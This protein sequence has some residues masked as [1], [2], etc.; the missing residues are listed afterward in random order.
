MPAQAKISAESLKVV[1]DEI[2]IQYEL[3][4]EHKQD[5]FDDLDDEEFLE[6]LGG[7]YALWAKSAITDTNQKNSVKSKQHFRKLKKHKSKKIKYKMAVL[8]LDKKLSHRQLHSLVKKINAKKFKHSKY[9]IANVFPNY[10][11]EI[12]SADQEVSV[13][14]NDSFYGQQWPITQIQPE[15]LWQYTKGA[16]AVVA[17]I[18]TG[19]DYNHEDLAENIWVNED[20]IPDNGKDDDRNGYIDDVRG[21]DFVDKGGYSCTSYEDCS[22]EDNDPMDV[23]GHGTH[24]AGIIAAVQNNNKGISG[25]APE[26]LIMPLKA[27]Y[28]TG[29]SGFLKTSDILEAITYAINN[30]ADVINMS[31]AGPELIVLE[32][33]LNFAFDLGIVCVAAAGNYGS[34]TKTYPAGLSSVIAVG[35]VDSQKYKAYYSNY[36][37]WV[38]VTAPGTYILST[39]PGNSYDYKTGTSMSAP[40]VSAV[41]ALLKAKNK[42]KKPTAQE[43]QEMLISSLGEVKYPTGFTGDDDMG[44]LSADIDFPLAIDSVELPSQVLVGSQATLKAKASDSSSEI[45][46][47][48][49]KSD[50]DGYMGNSE[51]LNFSFMSLGSHVVQVRAQNALGDWSSPELK[52]VEVVDKKPLTTNN[53]VAKRKFSFKRQNGYLVPRISNINKSKIKSLKWISSEDGTL[54]NKK[55]INLAN[56]SQGFHKI[57]LSVQDING[58]WSEPYQRVIKIN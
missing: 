19:V 35:A 32:D 2:I 36:G 15:K 57:S 7:D 50:I 12:N 9:Q 48:E 54:G 14:L 1:D 31:F 10:L 52:I 42:I 45:L 56:L 23:V 47:Y 51:N 4:P 53:F 40:H 25:I 16:G 26:A 11:Y 44:S 37:D 17:V 55:A 49:W 27:G 58:N 13:E 21:W 33:V 5:N 20:E 34:S 43:V 30:N 18:D 28:S 3:K 24:V 38:K 41:A 22:N 8:K 46:E 39:I 6:N 29:R